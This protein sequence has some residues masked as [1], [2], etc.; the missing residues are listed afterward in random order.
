MNRTILQGKK[1]NLDNWII[2]IEY[3]ILITIVKI[4]MTVKLNKYTLIDKN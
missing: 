3:I 4:E 1:F 2:Y